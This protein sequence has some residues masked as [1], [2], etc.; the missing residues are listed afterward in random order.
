MNTV[1]ASP[2][3]RPLAAAPAA[4]PTTR[5]EEIHGPDLIVDR[6]VPSN[7]FPHANE[8]VWFNVVVKNQGDQ[9]AGPFNLELTTAGV[10]QTV[11]AKQG[12]AAGAKISFNQM[13]PLFTGFPGSMEWVRAD[14][15][16]QN[17]VAEKRE[18]NNYLMTSISVQI[19]PFPPGPGPFPPVPPGPFPPH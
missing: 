18:D 17:E 10:D 1:A 15:D 12:L 11:R 7:S 13:G 19:D 2:Y 14:V 5:P 16:M 9:P 4:S 6:I 3:T 8:A